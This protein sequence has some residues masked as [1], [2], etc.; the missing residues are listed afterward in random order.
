MAMTLLAPLYIIVIIVRLV[1]RS[2]C[3]VPCHGC[4][5]CRLCLIFGILFFYSFCFCFC[6]YSFCFYSFLFS[7]TE[8]GRLCQLCTYISCSR[9]KLPLTLALSL[10]LSFSLHVARSLYNACMC[11]ACKQGCI[12]EIIFNF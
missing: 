1:L 9:H 5:C 2:M 11:Y 7:F 10:S 6:S 12:S 3:F 8:V 4:R